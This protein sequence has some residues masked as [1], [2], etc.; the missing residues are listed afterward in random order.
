M[1]SNTPIDLPT[2]ESVRVS[3]MESLALSIL[4]AERA[5][6]FTNDVYIEECIATA[7]TALQHAQYAANGFRA[8]NEMAVA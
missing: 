1:N 8:V 6:G 5:D 7:L 4:N 3:L 2:P